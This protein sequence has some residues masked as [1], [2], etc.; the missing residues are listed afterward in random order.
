MT[1]VPCAAPV[2]PAQPSEG[3]QEAP[4]ALEY[5]SAE[6]V[7]VEPQQKIRACASFSI[8]AH[9]NPCTRPLNVVFSSACA[10]CGFHRSDE[11]HRINS[12]GA[13]SSGALLSIV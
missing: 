10:R 11:R 13:H 9:S 6:E 4:Q 2:Q 7:G 5:G 12:M 3:L 8:R 1:Q